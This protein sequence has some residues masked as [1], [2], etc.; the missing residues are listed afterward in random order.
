MDCDYEITEAALIGCCDELWEDVKVIAQN[1]V[2]SV[3]VTDL[4]Q[5]DFFMIKER[6]IISDLKKM[7][8]NIDLHFYKEVG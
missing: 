3:Y 7:F 5:F 4:K 1:G 2:Y 6:I 8:S